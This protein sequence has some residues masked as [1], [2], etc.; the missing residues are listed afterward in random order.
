MDEFA[1]EELDYDLPEHLVAQTPADRRDESR[2]LVVNRQSGE[3]ADMSFTALPRLLRAEDVLVL[4][5]TRVVP[6]RLVLRRATGGRFEGLF[7]RELSAGRW[8]IMLKGRGRIRPGEQLAMGEPAAG[9]EVPV[10]RLESPQG[11]GVWQVAVEPPEPA[12]SLLACVGHTPLPPYIHRLVEGDGR[13]PADRDRY[14]T[15]YAR[16]P[17]AVA[18]P[19][20]GLHFTQA[21]METIAR[22]GVA[23]AHVTLH[24]GVG[25]FAP[26][27]AACLADHD[28]HSEWY[29][30]PEAA[31]ALITERRRAGGRVVAVG[32]TSVRVLESCAETD[33]TLR[34]GQ[35]WT[36]LFCYPPYRFRCVDAM[37]TNFHLPRSTLLAL[38][39]AFAGIENI[40]SAY[41]HAIREQYRFFSYGDAMFIT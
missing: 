35:G 28:M 27:K 34:P 19:T 24:V 13:E 16:A 8:E 25:T 33:G 14:Q 38:V 29:E 41:A 4:N 32:T 22:L 30:L 12:E 26:I 40:R 9:A 20:A 5:D 39:M 36:R 23:T 15:V 37:L 31:A 11:N 21:V 1:V 18:A 17:G 7:L 3:L 6:A 10:I 2:L